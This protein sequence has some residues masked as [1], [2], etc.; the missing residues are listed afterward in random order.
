VPRIRGRKIPYD[1]HIFD[2]RPELDR[3]KELRLIEKV[4]LVK[5]IEVHPVFQNFINGVYVGKY[6]ADTR[7]KRRAGARWET[8]V[9]DVKVPIT[10]TEACKLRM[11]VTAACHG[12][13]R[14]EVYMPARNLTVRAESLA[15]L[16]AKL[17]PK[18]V[19]KKWRIRDE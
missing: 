13:K 5:D 6:T 15:L 16:K 4:G 11:R 3:Y 8:V 10:N 19:R 12:F 9:E 1:G 2:S 17:K 18:S 7:Y 14:V